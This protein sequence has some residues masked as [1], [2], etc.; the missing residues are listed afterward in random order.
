MIDSD[1]QNPAHKKTP[2]DA[3]S[4]EREQLK[5]FLSSGDFAATLSE[6]NPSLAWLPVL[7]DM[8]LIREDTQVT[9]WVERN[10]ADVQAIRD[11]VA[12]IQFFGAEAASILEYRLNTQAH[13]LPSLLAK[14]WRLIIRQMRNSKQ[15]LARSEWF[16]IMPQIKR[17]DH[18]PALL[19]RIAD[20]MRPKLKIR[21]RFAW[22]GETTD[23]EPERPSDLMSIEY[24]VDDNMSSKDILDAW[25]A[26]TAPEADEALIA[27][28]TVALDAAL[29]DAT[30][31]GSEGTEGR[32]TSD[33]D[34]P[35]VATHGQNEYR[36][37]FQ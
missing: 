5:F 21:E 24:K 27:Q 14:C 19:E 13:N 31:V 18:S 9:A 32:S 35:S 3:T 2:A 7:W 11:V 37:G 29:R 6:V 10:F 17:G 34:V 12:N 4:F 20:I 28:L 25:P 16:E 15:G 1:K 23:K 8:K 30:D 33:I 36:S 26:T 22:R